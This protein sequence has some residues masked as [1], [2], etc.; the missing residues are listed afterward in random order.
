MS[1]TE[2]T[3]NEIFMNIQRGQYSLNMMARSGVSSVLQIYQLFC[4][5]HREHLLSGGE[6]KKFERFMKA[7][8][9]NYD[10]LRIPYRTPDR[11]SGSILSA[12]KKELDN[13]GIRYHVL[14]DLNP[15]DQAIQIC[16]YSKDRQ[17]FQAFFTSYLD[18]QLSGGSMQSEDLLSLT[19]K[20]ASILS[21]PGAGQE[22][23]IQKDFQSLGVNFAKLPDLH[24]GDG[25]IQ[26][27]VADA[28]LPKVRHWYSLYREDLLRAGE[29]PEDLRDLTISQYQDTAK[30]SAEEYLQAGAEEYQKT[31]APYEG[32]EKGETEQILEN[33]KQKPLDAENPEYARY[34]ADPNYTRLSID[35]ETLTD[36]GNAAQMQKMD[37]TH[38]YCRIPGTYGITEEILRLPA[39]QVFTVQGEERP[40]YIAFVKKQEKPEIYNEA[41][42]PISPYETGE[43]L[44]QQFDRVRQKFEKRNMQPIKEAVKQA[45]KVVPKA[46][47]V[48]TK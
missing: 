29:R 20:R 9:G 21:I 41:G 23:K 39:H 43:D 27:L 3:M 47:P 26:Y 34:L 31:V 1:E 25:Q 30:C 5:L 2:Q 22:E 33:L 14:P 11:E 24:V 18:Q 6:V 38:F 19:D 4:R 13:L 46:P 7:T 36:G 12:I 17:K 10:I 37:G 32:K 35:A 48:L 16:I 44:Y 28:D 45:V 42:Q 15:G 40:R 8:G